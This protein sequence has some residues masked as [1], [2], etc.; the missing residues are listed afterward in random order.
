MRTFESGP[1]GWTIGVWARVLCLGAT[2]GAGLLVGGV[3]LASAQN[4][5]STA[6]A[7]APGRAA[8][9]ATTFASPEAAYDHGLGALRGGHPEM[10][11][12]AFE[13][14]AEHDH[15][16]AQFYLARIYAD[17]AV[18]YTNHGRA[19]ELYQQIVTDH[20]DVDVD[21]DPR[22]PFVAKAMIALAGYYRTGIANAG[23]ALDLE[24]AAN[25][26]RNAAKSFRDEDAQFEFAKILLK[27]EGVTADPSEALYWLNGTAKRG[28]AGAQA[29][30]A[31]LY[32]RGNHV[33]KDP[34]QA[35]LLITLAAENAPAAERIWI[36]DT[37]QYIFCGAGEGVRRQA[38]GAVADWRTK[39][40]RSREERVGRDGLAA[41][42]PRAVRTCSNGEV[43]QPQ[44]RGEGSAEGPAKQRTEY[45]AGLRPASPRPDGP[46][47]GATNGFIQG[48]VS[49]FSRRDAG[50]T[51]LAPPR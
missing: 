45:S 35:L 23:V 16:L 7:P 1:R 8:A 46:A 12:K 9:G 28:L 13:F 42:Q 17:N 33:P 22:A 47:P 41:I 25:L 18:S 10:A 37:Y 21:D 48:N 51:T 31:D 30:L 14:A 26:L 34:T 43:A 50:Q 38:L 19:F 40:G 20:V 27:G 2:L 36:E 3:P 5:R 49:G 29:F 4:L 6:A 15:F 24:R 11:I 39:Y 32:W 44:R